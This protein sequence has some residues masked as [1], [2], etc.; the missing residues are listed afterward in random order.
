MN[1]SSQPPYDSVR[2]IDRAFA[3][4]EALRIEG[5]PT[6]MSDIAERVDLPQPTVHRILRTLVF[7]GY[8]HQVASRRY[9]LGTGLIGLARGA[10]SSLGTSLRPL[11]LWAVEATR[12]AASLAIL[13]QDE[14]RYI[15]NVSSN[16]AV[17]VFTQVGNR[18]SLHS[19]GVGKAVLS[20]MPDDEAKATIGRIVLNRL[21]PTTITDPEELLA[22]VRRVRD[23]GY[24]I[25]NAE[26]DIG[27]KCVAAAIPGTLPLAVS[28]SGP[29]QRMNDDYLESACLPVVRKLAAQI[30]EACAQMAATA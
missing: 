19:T 26:H 18:A 24:A 16:Q 28:I 27:V 7:G 17:R 12:E 14:M 30:G 3:V 8:A 20:A 13:D 9:T 6:T 21:T 29:E 4:L 10:G 23:R 5:G 25:D 1:P 2:A 11:L 15:A 22:E